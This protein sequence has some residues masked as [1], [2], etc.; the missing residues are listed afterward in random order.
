MEARCRADVLQ[1]QMSEQI[2]SESNVSEMKAED[3]IT[4]GEKPAGDVVSSPRDSDAGSDIVM[5]AAGAGTDGVG[6]ETA[7]EGEGDA[8]GGDV[9]A[10]WQPTSSNE[11]ET[12][13]LSSP[14]QTDS[15]QVEATDASV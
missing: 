12:M 11:P 1:N 6:V 14:D 10:T 4:D 9:F 3:P 7:Q 2:I 5:S 13:P 15:M 8:S